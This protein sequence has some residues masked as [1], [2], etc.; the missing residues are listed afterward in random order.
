MTLLV[1]TH[2]VLEKGP[3]SDNTQLA[4]LS[5]LTTQDVF[6]RRVSIQ[7]KLIDD[8]VPDTH[9]GSIV[10]GRGC[11]RGSSCESLTV[12]PRIGAGACAS[13]GGE[14]SMASAASATGMH[15]AGAAMVRAATLVV[16]TL[17]VLLPCGCK[18]GCGCEC[19]C[20]CKS[21]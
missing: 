3:L 8:V 4:L 7:V 1:W 9:R 17:P 15:V 20:K 13:V 18:C 5:V 2:V 14:G 11:G 16:V 19:G 10:K 21:G 6:P 12:V